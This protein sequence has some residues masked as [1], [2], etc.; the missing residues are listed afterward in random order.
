MTSIAL[1]VAKEL[2]STVGSTVSYGS[3]LSAAVVVKV[4]K[5]AIDELRQTDP[6]PDLEFSDEEDEDGWNILTGDKG[7]SDEIPGEKKQESF[8]VLFRNYFSND[9]KGPGM[10][11]AEL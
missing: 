4:G 6:Q 2:A 7:E 5:I 8:T 3:L 9:G 11:I 1:E 10:D